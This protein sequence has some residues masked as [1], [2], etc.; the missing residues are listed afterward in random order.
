MSSQSL[1]QQG[2]TLHRAGKFAEAEAIYRRILA[3]ETTNVD[4]MQMLGVLA[5]QTGRF[6]LAEQLL[7]QAAGIAPH[8]AGIQNNLGLA[9]MHQEKHA[10]AATAFERNRAATRVT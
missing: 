4:V 9:L 6:A 2:M 3:I 10:D 7:R 8:I 1:F 5:S